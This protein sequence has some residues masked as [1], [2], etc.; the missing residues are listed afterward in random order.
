MKDLKELELPRELAW[1]G[2]HLSDLAITALADG[3]EA[4]LGAAVV[5]HMEACGDCA[6]RVG[7]AALLS[8]AIGEAVAVARP[9]AAPAVARAAASMHP[10]RALLLGLTVAAVA[11]VPVLRD[12]A[13][14]PGFWVSLVIRSV[15]ALARGGLAFATSDA[16]KRGLPPATLAAA[17]LLFFMGWVVARWISNTAPATSER[18][19]S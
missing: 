14:A 9:A 3:E 11:A 6:G 17:V 10:W 4:I 13:S 16:V 15:K 1:D 7:R 8:S 12:V 18:S 2:E 19:A 5:A